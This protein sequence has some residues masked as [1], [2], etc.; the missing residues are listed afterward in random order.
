QHQQDRAD[1]PGG[2]EVAV[3]KGAQVQ[4]D[5]QRSAVGAV[6][7]DDVAGDDLGRAGGEQQGRALAHDTAD[8]QDAAGDDA[9]DAAGQDN[10]ADQV[11][12][13]R[14]QTHGALAVAHGDRLEGFLGGADDGGQGHNDQRQAAGQQAGLE[15]QGLG[16]HQHTHQAVD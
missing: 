8:G 5:G 13:A 16:E 3:F 7:L 11:P 2:I 1:A 14:A 6:S 4:Q 9:V 12:L 15:A 10:G